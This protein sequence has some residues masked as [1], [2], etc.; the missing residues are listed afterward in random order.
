VI[1]RLGLTQ[2]QINESLGMHQMV[3][4]SISNC[5]IDLRPLLFNNIVVTGGNTLFPGFNERLNYELPMM[6]PGVSKE[7]Q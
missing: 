2:Q 6:A 3:Y 7:R 5:D 1:P 4:Q